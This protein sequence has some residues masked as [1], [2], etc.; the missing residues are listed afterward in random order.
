MN[1]P[2]MEWAFASLSISGAIVTLLAGGYL[3]PFDQRPLI[4][5]AGLMAL[6][7]WFVIGLHPDR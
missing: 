1:R 2:R 7:L 5:A 3:M 4:L 6:S